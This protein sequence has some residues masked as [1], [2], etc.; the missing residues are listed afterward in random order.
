MIKFTAATI[1]ALQS[2]SID[3]CYTVKIVELDGTLVKAITS[4]SYDLVLSDAATVY[5]ADGT[6]VSVQPPKS[7]TVVDRA[8][9]ELVIADPLFMEGTKADNGYISNFV[10]VRMILLG[11]TPKMPLTNIEDTYLMYAGRVDGTAYR[12]NT[13]TI[14]EAVLKI[15]CSSPMANLDH[16]KGLYLSRDATRNRNPNDTCCDDIYFGSRT[17]QL[18]WGKS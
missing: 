4:N 8:M 17:V 11:G 6:L 7:S 15:K 10:E 9:Y 2:P 3:F 18:K 14:G 13:N 16:K 1:A 5:V 12:V